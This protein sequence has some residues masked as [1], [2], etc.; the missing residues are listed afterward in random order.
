MIVGGDPGIHIALSPARLEALYMDVTQLTTETT[1]CGSQLPELEIPMINTMVACLASEHRRL[2]EHTLSLALAANRLAGDSDAFTADQPAFAI[3]DEIRA[4]LYSHLQIEDALVFS[5][6]QDHQAISKILLEALKIERQEMGS[7]LAAAAAPL[8]EH[9][10]P[11][12]TAERRALAQTLLEH[13]ARFDGE[14]LPSIRRALFQGNKAPFA[15][16][17]A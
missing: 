9:Q 17:R 14:I 12:T 8:G 10:T 3:W 11:P 1:P 16:T 7:L 4:Y 15:A 5:W 6:G 13:I 2:D